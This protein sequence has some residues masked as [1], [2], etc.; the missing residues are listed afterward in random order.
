MFCSACGTENPVGNR[1]CMKCGAA[2]TNVV[3]LPQHA[4][5]GARIASWIIDS[6]V[7][8]AALIVAPIAAAIVGKIL[9]A[10]HPPTHPPSRGTL[11]RCSSSSWWRRSSPS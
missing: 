10:T 2:M 11:W 8:L 3:D 7:I 6:L 4:R 5:I 9:A 1:F